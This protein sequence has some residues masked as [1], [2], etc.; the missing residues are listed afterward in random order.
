MS[1]VIWR[2]TRPQCCDGCEAAIAERFYDA[3]TRLGPWA[4]MCPQCFPLYG[5]G[6]GTG[7]GQEFTKDSAGAYAKTGG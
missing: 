5:R 6:L 2:G 7:V 1:E 3:A 4:L